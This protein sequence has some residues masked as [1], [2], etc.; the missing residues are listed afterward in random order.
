MA[1]NEKK[2]R[3]TIRARDIYQ[4][5]KKRQFRGPAIFASVLGLFLL[6]LLVFYGM[7]SFAVY[8][9]EGNATIVLPFSQKSEENQQDSGIGGD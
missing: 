9:E 5:R 1:E 3:T 8:D 4:G 2:R 6:A 7:R